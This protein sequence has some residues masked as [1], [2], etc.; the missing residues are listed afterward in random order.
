MAD[1]HRGPADPSHV[2]LSEEYEDWYWVKELGGSQAALEEAVVA[3]G[4]SADRVR[5]HLKRSHA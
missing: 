5:Q 3:I 2:S 1:D 4:S